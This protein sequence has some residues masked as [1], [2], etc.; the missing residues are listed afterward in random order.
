MNRDLK[1][2]AAP[3]LLTKR[4]IRK[5][6]DPILRLPFFGFQRDHDT[7]LGLRMILDE[8]SNPLKM[9]GGDYDKIHSDPAGE[10]PKA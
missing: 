6:D 3:E 8:A 1:D 2:F 4:L 7:L 9:V 5:N 10:S